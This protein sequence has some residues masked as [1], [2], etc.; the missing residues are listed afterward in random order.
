M[1]NVV[2]FNKSDRRDT[3]QNEVAA[4]SLHA[5]TAQDLSELMADNPQEFLRH[6]QAAENSLPG[7]R[8]MTS[9]YHQHLVL[10]VRSLQAENYDLKKTIEGTAGIPEA[11][12]IMGF[13]AGQLYQRRKGNSGMTPKP[14]MRISPVAQYRRKGFLSAFTDFGKIMVITITLVACVVIGAWLGPYIFGR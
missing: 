1:S 4:A 11:I 6:I 9:A 12:L 14:G 5:T 3:A 2:P 7:L 8:R 13:Y 10:A